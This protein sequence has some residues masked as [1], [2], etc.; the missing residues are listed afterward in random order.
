M[1]EGGDGTHVGRAAMIQGG[2]IASHSPGYQTPSYATVLHTVI[3]VF[4]LLKQNNLKFC[5]KKNPVWHRL[6]KLV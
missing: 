3:G 2:V 1:P 5:T 6:F 4:A